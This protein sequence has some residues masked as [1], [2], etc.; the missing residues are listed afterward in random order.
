MRNRSPAA[1]RH[2]AVFRISR[3]ALRRCGRQ[4]PDLSAAAVTGL[5]IPAISYD[6][7]DRHRGSAIGSPAELLYTPRLRATIGFYPK[8]IGQRQSRRHRKTK[9]RSRANPGWCNTTRTH[10]ALCYS[11]KACS[12][13]TGRNPLSRK[14]NCAGPAEPASAAQLKPTKYCRSLGPVMSW[15]GYG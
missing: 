10:P 5:R 1:L 2:Q 8:S 9:S 3:T 15:F 12:L 4:Q 7:Q 11:P 6:R 13:R 14:L